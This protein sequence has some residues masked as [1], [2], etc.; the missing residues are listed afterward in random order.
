MNPLL[1]AIFNGLRKFTRKPSNSKNNYSH[2]EINSI[3]ASR[4]L[5]QARRANLNSR[6]A[7]MNSAWNNHPTLQLLQK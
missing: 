1:N 3:R 6:A 7:R 5:K 2:A 4:I